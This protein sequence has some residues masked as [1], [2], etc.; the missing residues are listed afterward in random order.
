MWMNRVQ[1]AS[2]AFLFWSAVVEV[3]NSQQTPT[4]RTRVAAVPLD[5]HVVDRNGKPVNDLKEAD[6]TILEN[7]V[8]QQISHFLVR[9][10]FAEPDKA[11]LA[12]PTSA[13]GRTDQLLASQTRRIFLIVLGSGRLQ[14]PSQG[15]DA[16]IHFVSRQ[17]LPQD[18]AAVLAFNRATDFTADHEKLAKIL[19]R[20]K[21][22]NDWLDTKI[23]FWRSSTAALFNQNIPGYIQTEIDAVFGPAARTSGTPVGSGDLGRIEGETRATAGKVFER[24]VRSKQ[25]SKSA[26]A[27]F[28]ELLPELGFDEYI[29]STTQAMTDLEMILAGI[30]Y[31]RRFEGEKHLMFVTEYGLYIPHEADGDLMLAKVANDARVAIDMIQT[32]GLEGSIAVMPGRAL[33]KTWTR[34]QSID[35]IPFLTGGQSS[36]TEYTRN[37]LDTINR[38]TLT[39]YLIAYYPSNPKLDGKYRRIEV[40]VNRPNVTVTF[41]HGYYASN[42][43]VIEREA[44][45]ALRRISAAGSYPGDIPDIGIRLDA[46]VGGR[47][48]TGAREVT[49]DLLIDASRL[50]FAEEAGQHLATL[51]VAIYCSDNRERLLG[52]LRR[53]ATLK[54]SEETY[55]TSL[56]RGIPYSVSLPVNGTP[57]YVKAIVYDHKADLVGSRILKLK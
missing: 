21:A 42:E 30:D 35:N 10:I 12:T 17:L 48:T 57:R 19:E 43:P 5:V 22:K 40:K 3:Q 7:G 56:Q 23:K 54:L 46:R 16:L 8:P 11:P 44:L 14:E 36:R 50:S 29:A 41:R 38:T 2:L 55:Q 18:Y 52:E 1:I 25:Q 37:G 28:D 31:L 39:G 15:L 27:L 53:K 6:F 9:R 33:L 24:D 47:A 20:Y 26:F 51:D 34:M 45:L 32:G 49:V 13:E 4:F